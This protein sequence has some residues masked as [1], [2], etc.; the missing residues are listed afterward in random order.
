M[1]TGCTG[2]C[3]VHTGDPIHAKTINGTSARK[4]WRK[5]LNADSERTIFLGERNTPDWH[6]S[7][8]ALKCYGYYSR[9]GSIFMIPSCG[10]GDS[11]Y[12]M[13]PSKQLRKWNYSKYSVGG[14]FALSW[15]TLYFEQTYG[16]QHIAVA[17]AVI[18]TMILAHAFTLQR[19]SVPVT[20]YAS[21]RSSDV[22]VCECAHVCDWCLDDIDIICT[23]VC[24]YLVYDRMR[25]TMPFVCLSVY[26]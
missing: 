19:I 14:N 18:H 9:Q 8:D 7:E 26:R 1:H 12:W 6:N 2:D 17:V 20:R 5:T 21:R 10:D 4:F 13:C 11:L 3:T 23:R 24:R 25:R 22:F 15:C 16:F